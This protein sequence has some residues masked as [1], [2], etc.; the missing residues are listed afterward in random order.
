[1]SNFKQNFTAKK[2]QAMQKQKCKNQ[3]F[4]DTNLELFER[5]G[6]SLA[7]LVECRMM[8][9]VTLTMIGHQITKLDSDH[10]RRRILAQ[11]VSFSGKFN[12]LVEL[13]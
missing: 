2:F 4:Q 10:S 6:S 7:G 11:C 8:I 9:I 12:L 3:L 5:L 13:R 1:M